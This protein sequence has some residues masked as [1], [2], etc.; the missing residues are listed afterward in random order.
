MMK[1]I[2]GYIPAAVVLVPFITAWI[3]QSLYYKGCMDGAEYVFTA[4]FAFVIGGILN[5]IF[6]GC[7]A[8]RRQWFLSSSS[9]RQRKLAKGALV[10]G[11]F[12]AV[13]QIAVVGYLMWQ[14]MNI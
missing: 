2:I 3:R 14:K 1:A 5:L 4:F 6:L 12:T 11:L 9:D 13:F 8:G 10:V 7:F